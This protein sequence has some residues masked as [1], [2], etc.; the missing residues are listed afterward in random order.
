MYRP[1]GFGTSSGCPEITT[2]ATCDPSNWPA[3]QGAAPTSCNEIPTGCQTFHSV[4]AHG[5][6]T[7]ITKQRSYNTKERGFYSTH[8]N[9]PTGQGYWLDKFGSLG[10]QSSDATV[11]LLVG[12]YVAQVLDASQTT[13]MGVVLI[14]LFYTSVAD[15]LAPFNHIGNSVVYIMEAA[16]GELV[17]TS[18][19]EAIFDS[20]TNIT[21][22]AHTRQH[23]ECQ[24]T[25]SLC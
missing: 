3:L 4:N 23:L 21:P 10:Y 18:N 19:G 25:R 17:A 12:Y 2:G 5:D 22:Y 14:Q 1:P 24:V 11:P 20:S 15:I 13:T 8:T 9:Y 6:P 7:T 16:T